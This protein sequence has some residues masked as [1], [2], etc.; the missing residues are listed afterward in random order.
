MIYSETLEPQGGHRVSRCTLRIAI[1]LDYM[2]DG[3]QDDPRAIAL[4]EMCRVNGI[5]WSHTLA[6]ND[7]LGQPV[8]DCTL[9]IE[10]LMED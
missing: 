3:L 6:P 5:G 1:P 10:N 9:V 2:P 8:Y 7:T 4:R